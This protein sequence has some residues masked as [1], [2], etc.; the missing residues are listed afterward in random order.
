MPIKVTCSSCGGVLHAPDDAAGKKGRCPTC[1][2]VLTIPADEPIPAPPM[3]S[4]AAPL[5]PRPAP[6]P[7]DAPVP[8]GFGPRPPAGGYGLAPDPAPRPPGTGSSLAGGPPAPGRLGPPPAAVG[9]KLPPDPRR[10]SSDPFVSGSPAAAARRAVADADRWRRVHGGLGWV[11]AAAVFGFLAVVGFAALPV[12]QAYGVPVPDQTPGYLQQPDISSAVEIRAAATLGPLAL[13]LLC[14]AFGRM[15]VSAAPAGSFAGGPAK[16]AG[17]A[18]LIL[19]AAITAV[20]A[21]TAL[22]LKEGFTPKW[23]HKPGDG[24]YAQAAEVLRGSLMSPADVPGQVQRFGLAAA[25]GFGLMAE[26]WFFATLGRIAAA[27]QSR[28]A[29]GRV[30]RFL[31]L[32]GLAVI[33]KLGAFVALEVYGFDWLEQHVLSHW[34]GLDGKLQ[35]ATSAGAAAVAA[36]VFAV[37]Y[38]RAVGG[39]RGAIREYLDLA[40]GA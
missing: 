2:T 24:W 13:A 7:A 36:L 35:L 33:A 40:P 26:V 21:M 30:N 16:A 10:Y 22:G 37:L 28:T 34:R 4:G 12:A 25:V 3:S 14:L 15:G 8:S 39:V 5:P 23:T 6:P 27:L 17:F 1:G 19:L 32:A 11:R 20:G 29:A 38:M 31:L 9:S 18:T